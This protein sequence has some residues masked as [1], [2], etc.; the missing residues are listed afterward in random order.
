VVIHTEDRKELL[1][2]QSRYDTVTHF[3]AVEIGGSLQKT[4]LNG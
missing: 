3:A 1:K 4:P 2:K